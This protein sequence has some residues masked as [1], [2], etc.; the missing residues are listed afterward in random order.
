MSTMTGMMHPFPV[1]HNFTLPEG[2]TAVV[3]P[4]AS[5]TTSTDSGHPSP[6]SSQGGKVLVT[7]GD[8][9]S[10][11][12]EASP[13]SSSNS[14]DTD[15]RRVS[16]RFL[17]GAKNPF[18]HVQRV[19]HRRPANLFDSWRTDSARKRSQSLADASELFLGDR[20]DQRPLFF[21]SNLPP[22]PEV[23][24]E[25]AKKQGECNFS[26]EV[27][28]K[29]PLSSHDNRLDAAQGLV[30]LGNMATQFPGLYPFPPELV[31][32]DVM[33]PRPD[34]LQDFQ[35]LRTPFD[36]HNPCYLGADPYTALAMRRWL[37]SPDVFRSSLNP[38]L[39][40]QA[41][42]LTP[43]ERLRL[44]QFPLGYH[45]PFPGPSPFDLG[46]AP[47]LSERNFPEYSI[48][49]FYRNG[50]M[51]EVIRGSAPK[52]QGKRHSPSTE[53]Q[54]NVRDGSSSPLKKRLNPEKV[55]TVKKETVDVDNC[56]ERDS[57]KEE[58]LA[59][60]RNISSCSGDEDYDEEEVKVDVVGG[61][62]PTSVLRQT[63]AGI[64]EEFTSRLENLNTSFAQSLDHTI[65]GPKKD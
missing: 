19:D 38:L 47:G 57:A 58:S 34:M 41:G 63:F 59:P 1:N 24:A 30:S 10:D 52:E 49:G 65:V 27:P 3:S 60:E 13:S 26:C 28:T 11:M 54:P 42:L 2:H 35:H 46:P 53:K 56:D 18:M 7:D 25:D 45:Y 40:A 61:V 36:I 22:I 55:V 31:Y 23:K 32:P 51:P 43:A 44:L 14:Q 4:L 64:Q 5:P 6:D 9:R 16:E 50:L 62:K 39:A 15:G 37:S 29:R 8:I 48:H 17:S 12:R 21:Q 33:F 20:S